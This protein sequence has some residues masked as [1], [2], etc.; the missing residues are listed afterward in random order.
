[1]VN[2]LINLNYDILSYI[3]SKFDTMYS[4]D[5]Y[6][7]Y[8]TKTFGPIITNQIKQMIGQIRYE[9][10]MM[11]LKKTNLNLKDYYINLYKLS[12]KLIDLPIIEYYHTLNTEI[13]RTMQLITPDEIKLGISNTVD[14]SN[15]VEKM[16]K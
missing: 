10:D 14:E 9:N 13:G 2:Y 15:Y 7:E 5:N 1:M 12:E 4:I 6:I 11:I 16:N 8:I 3:G